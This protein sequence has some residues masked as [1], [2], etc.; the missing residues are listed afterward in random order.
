MLHPPTDQGLEWVAKP[1]LKGAGEI[2]SVVSDS[3]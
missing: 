1:N 3:V 2:L